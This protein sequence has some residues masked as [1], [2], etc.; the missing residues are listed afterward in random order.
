MTPIVLSIGTSHPWNVAGTGRDLTVGAHFG[1]RIFTAIAAVSAQDG[2]G[3]VALH[4]IPPAVFR[5]Q[6]GVLPWDSA[7]GVRVGALPT[8]AAVHAVADALQSHPWLAAVVDPV[9]SASRGG[10]LV[11]PAARY[12]VR[13]EIARLPNVVLTP[14]LDEAS[15]LLGD[16]G[17]I[18]R[19]TIGDSAARLRSRGARAVLL[20]G[21]HLDGKPIDAL[22][23]EA[24]VELFADARIAGQMHGTGCTLA[25]ALACGLALGKSLETAVRDARSFVRAELARH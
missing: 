16:G 9:F 23:T 13:D 1:I 25:M 20:T 11:E 7:G 22:A 14:N 24:G 10:A 2:R 18:D 12:A 5:A 21:G 6:L 19:E 17:V 4:D 15:F 8:T 3:V